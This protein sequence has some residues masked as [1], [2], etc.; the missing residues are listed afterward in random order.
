M[1]NKYN[2]IIATS[3]QFYDT[4]NLLSANCT[5]ARTK[6]TRTFCETNNVLFP[7]CL[8]RTIYVVVSICLIE[9]KPSCS[10]IK[11]TIWA[12]QQQRNQTCLQ[13]HLPRGQWHICLP[14]LKR[15]QIPCLTQYRSTIFVGH[16]TTEAPLVIVGP[17]TTTDN[18]NCGWSQQD[19]HRST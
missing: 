9:S 16:K 12:R 14:P 4:V 10:T 11:W 19:Q 5:S 3:L 7:F 18:P 13:N 2:R 17:T 6:Q 1:N 8:P 15:H